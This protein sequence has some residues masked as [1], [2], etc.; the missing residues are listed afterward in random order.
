MIHAVEVLKAVT[1]EFPEPVAD[2]RP[3]THLFN[4]IPIRKEHFVKVGHK[5]MLVGLFF[6]NTL[7]IFL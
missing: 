1:N 7:D 3:A 5:V 4:L 6:K 2:F